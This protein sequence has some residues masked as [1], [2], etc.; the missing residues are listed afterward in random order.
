MQMGAMP[1]GGIESC[2]PGLRPVREKMGCHRCFFVL[3]SLIEYKGGDSWRGD[4]H[5]PKPLNHRFQDIATV[6]LPHP[7][8][9]CAQPLPTLPCIPT[10][11][12][13]SPPSIKCMYHTRPSRGRHP[14]ASPHHH[15]AGVKMTV[16]PWRT[17]LHSWSGPQMSGYAI[18]GGGKDGV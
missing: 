17:T 1:V 14:K 5:H 16:V 10:H 6:A 15:A 3:E 9:T 11:L 4:P 2:G 7:A 18:W 13:M 12:P 8:P